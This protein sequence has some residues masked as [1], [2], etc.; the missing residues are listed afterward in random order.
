MIA[1][2]R[3]RGQ[4]YRGELFP[5]ASLVLMRY[6]GKLEGQT[7]EQD[8]VRLCGSGS[9]RQHM[10]MWNSCVEKTSWFVHVLREMLVYVRGQRIS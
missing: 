6:N 2:E 10:N 8:G 9:T 7:S 1:Y 4:P 3:V 5:F